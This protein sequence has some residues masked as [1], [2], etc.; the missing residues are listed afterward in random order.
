MGTKPLERLAEADD[1]EL[2]QGH[3]EEAGVHQVQHGVLVAADVAVHRQPLRRQ[4]RLDG[5]VVAAGGGVAEEVPAA[6]QKVVGDVGVAMGVLATGRAGGVEPV[7]GPRQGALAAVVGAEVLQV[8][9][10][11]RQFA[12]RHRHRAA[13]GAVDD[14]N[15]RSPVPLPGHAPVVQPVVGLRLGAALGFEPCNDGPLGVRHRQAVE[16]AGVHQ[17]AFA[18]I[19]LGQGRFG[20]LPRSGDHAHDGQAEGLGELEVAGVMARHR[21]DRPG[22]V[23]HEHVVGYPDGNPRAVHRIDGVAAG[24]HAGLFLVG[25]LPF[26]E[27]PAG[28]F[29]PIGI[30]FRLRI[31]SG[32]G[33]HQRMLRGQHHVGGPEQG[34]RPGG[35][36]ADTGAP[37]VFGIHGAIGDA[38]ASSD[39]EADIGALAAADPSGLRF[40]GDV[41]P[42]HVG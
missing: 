20:I 5:E 31:G 39:G 30:H 4:L 13:I 26:H 14:G 11:H 3:G 17:G 24:E 28:D 7:L 42:V 19:G 15:G 29:G 35:E 36:H 25:L 40:L 12:F 18:R 6:A 38:A 41:G 22:A 10:F 32:D 23:A 8:G 34:V 9:E 1:A 27:V 37:A 21:H 2:M 16:F 33:V